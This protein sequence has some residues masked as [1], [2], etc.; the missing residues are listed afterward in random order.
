MCAK[1]LRLSSKRRTLIALSEWLAA[2]AAVW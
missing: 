2:I 1:L